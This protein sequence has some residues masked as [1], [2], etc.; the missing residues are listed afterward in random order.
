[1]KQGDE[2]VRELRLQ[3]LVRAADRAMARRSCLLM[4][5]ARPVERLE[6]VDFEVN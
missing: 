3:E 1:M 5:L 4:L 6:S 2:M